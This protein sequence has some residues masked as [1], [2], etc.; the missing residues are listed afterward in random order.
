MSH[1]P[2][3]Q[4][5]G[6]I[7]RIGALVYDT[8]LILVLEI[9]AAAVIVLMLE[10]MVAVGL[11][12][13]GIDKD[14][15]GFLTHN[16]FWSSIFT[17]YLAMIWIGFFVW[18]WTQKGQ[19]LGMKAWRLMVS[20]ADGT[21]ITITQALIRLFTSGFGLS[22]LTVPLDPQKRGFHDIWAKTNLYVIPK[23][24]A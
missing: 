12:H 11:L 18:F 24:D 14:V 23:D 17:A 5:A 3:L 20:N 21:P 4:T 8:C 1:Q 16:P 2:H 19:T 7:R 9:L 6:F 22:N 13:Y 15:S 10:A